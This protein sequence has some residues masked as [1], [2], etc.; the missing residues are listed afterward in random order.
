M[1]GGKR[2]THRWALWHYEVCANHFTQVHTERLHSLVFLGI[3]GI[4]DNHL[5]YGVFALTKSK[6]KPKIAFVKDYKSLD[7]NE[8]KAD[9]ARAPWHTIG[10]LEDIDDSVFLWESM[11]R[12]FFTT[13]LRKEL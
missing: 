1:P 11:F 10:A 13:T 3:L 2:M 5:V 4:S 9:M 12:A 8:L 6:P 7:L